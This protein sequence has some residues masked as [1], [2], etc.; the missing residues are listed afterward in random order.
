DKNPADFFTVLYSL[1][2]KGVAFQLIVVGEKSET[3]PTVFDEAKKKLSKHILH[4]GYVSTKAAYLS[5][6]LKSDVLPV[7]S[8]QD[9]FGISVVEAVAAGVTPVLPNRL[10]FPEIIDDKKYSDF[11][12]SEGELEAALCSTIKNGA[13]LPTEELRK[14]MIK[15]DWSKLSD[16]Y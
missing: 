14:S 1:S 5:L 7:T 9:F 6:L 12:Y 10:A 2:A 3:Y 8:C 15:Y 11:F 4:W 13:A 16:K